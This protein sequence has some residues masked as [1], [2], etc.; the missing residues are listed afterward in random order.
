MP[1]TPGA[2]HLTAP[3]GSGRWWD[4]GCA[5]P[6]TTGTQLLITGTIYAQKLK[7]PRGLAITKIFAE[8][9]TGGAAGKLIRLGLY[10]VGA[11]GLPDALLADTGSLAA[12]V[13]GEIGA[14]SSLV[15][16]YDEVWTAALS[17]GAPTLRAY[18][19]DRSPQFMGWSSATATT[20]ETALT[21]TQAYGALPATF[22]TP[23]SYVSTPLR[24]GVKS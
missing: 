17:D 2:P 12:D 20:R 1:I 11:D 24:V 7:I 16:P 8:I 5:Y 3:F 13:T 22:G 10:T 23:T 6:T 9:A 21:K 15:L 19:T 18:V 4:Y 14:S